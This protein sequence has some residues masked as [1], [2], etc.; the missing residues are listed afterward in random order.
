MKQLIDRKCCDYAA[1]RVEVSPEVKTMTK[2]THPRIT[3]N[4]QT[5]I[6]VEREREREEASHGKMKAKELGGSNVPL[7][8]THKP[9]RTT[10]GWMRRECDVAVILI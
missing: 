4:D 3:P 8:A 6:I 7:F 5:T 2:P 9:S 10:M 1:K